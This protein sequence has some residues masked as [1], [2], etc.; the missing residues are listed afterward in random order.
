M[1][2][3]KLRVS[4]LFFCSGVHDIRSSKEILNKH[5][6]KM[7]GR[8]TRQSSPSRHNF[9]NRFPLVHR[10]A[11]RNHTNGRDSRLTIHCADR[12]NHYNPHQ[13]RIVTVG[14]YQR[15]SN[16]CIRWRRFPSRI[17]RNQKNCKTHHPQVFC[18]SPSKHAHNRSPNI[19]L[20]CQAPQKRNIQKKR[21]M[22]TASKRNEVS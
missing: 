5:L 3:Q 7:V 22:P 16:E 12:D 8:N 2:P 6:N 1:R 10:H 4:A 13:K 15:H 9:H 11:D 14:T 20:A 21:G 19:L 18:R 17:L